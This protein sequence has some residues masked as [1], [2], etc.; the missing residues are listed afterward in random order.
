ME[1]VR[2]NLH[3]IDTGLHCPLHQRRN[4]FFELVLRKDIRE[5]LVLV[6]EGQIDFGAR[7]M[8]QILLRLFCAL[9]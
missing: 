1:W 7:H 4:Q 3:R 5:V 2:T 8:V 6:Y 9:S